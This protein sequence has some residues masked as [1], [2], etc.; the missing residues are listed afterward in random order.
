MA[1][2]T[3][4]VVS[5]LKTGQTLFKLLFFGIGVLAIVVIIFD[6]PKYIKVLFSLLLL[7]LK[8]YKLFIYYK[9]LRK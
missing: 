6:T 1:F 5:T 4:T 2:F 9:Y 7:K 3:Q 8:I